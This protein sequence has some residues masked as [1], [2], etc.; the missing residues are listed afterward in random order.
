MSHQTAERPDP[1]AE[2]IRRQFGS[3]AVRRYLSSLP[4]FGVDP[5]VPDRL[6]D[7]LADLKQVEGRRRR[8][9]GGKPN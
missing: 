4:A 5:G 2:D 7:L 1:L 6:R 9:S 8:R 3:T